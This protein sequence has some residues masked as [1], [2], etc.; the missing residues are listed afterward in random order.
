[1]SM[2]AFGTNNAAIFRRLGFYLVDFV[3]LV[4]FN[5]DFSRKNVHYNYATSFAIAVLLF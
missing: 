2:Y 1:M 4:P 3:G 5:V